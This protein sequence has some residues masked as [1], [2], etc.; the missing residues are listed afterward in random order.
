MC[1]LIPKA[2]SWR[3]DYRK[4]VILY[5]RVKIV[6]IAKLVDP[7]HTVICQDSMDNYR[8]V[9]N[10]VMFKNVFV[11]TLMHES[12]PLRLSA[13]NI[14]D[15]E[16]LIVEATP[17][18]PKALEFVGIPKYVFDPL[19]YK[20]K[21]AGGIKCNASLQQFVGL[22]SVISSLDQKIGHYFANMERY[23][24]LGMARGLNF[25]FVGP[26]GTGK[27]TLAHA[28]AAKYGMNICEPYALRPELSMNP[29]LPDKNMVIMDDFVAKT[30]GFVELQKMIFDQALPNVVRIFI[31]NDIS[32]VRYEAFVSRMKAVVTFP[33]PTPEML[34]VH[35]E[36]L[37]M[38]DDDENR[39][40]AKI[41]I[42]HVFAAESKRRA[43]YD[44]T[45]ETSETSEKLNYS[46]L[47]YRDFNYFISSYLG[48]DQG[49]CRAAMEIEQ[50]ID[51]R[52]ISGG[53]T[54]TCLNH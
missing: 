14:A 41:I 2:L 6:N 35:L 19:Y 34:Y 49:L 39:R 54:N 30:M 48:E 12:Y 36:R 1:T 25:L 29:D 7:D 50:W 40:Y 33:S 16:A 11:E 10:P 44:K 26:P 53:T 15:I 20:Y 27:T 4:T 23:M 3:N 51:D 37:F 24:D 9:V 45:V 8:A 28:L 17:P 38:I 52:N 18:K 47:G 32:Q 13:D 43:I 31:V 42:K 21:P 46:P 22:D 5:D